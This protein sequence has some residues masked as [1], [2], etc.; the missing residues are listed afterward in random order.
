MGYVSAIA[1]VAVASAI[2]V[3]A[4]P[5]SEVKDDVLAARRDISEA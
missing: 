4:L 5:R 3:S 2:I 1:I